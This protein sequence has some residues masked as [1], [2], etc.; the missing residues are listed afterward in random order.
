MGRPLKRWGSQK[1]YPLADKA[2]LRGIE[3]T[4]IVRIKYGIPRFTISGF[5]LS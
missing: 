5:F 3:G 4:L 1:T 2:N